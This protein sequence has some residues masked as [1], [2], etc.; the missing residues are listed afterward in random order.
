MHRDLFQHQ[1]H[2]RRQEIELAR[3]YRLGQELASACPTQR[4]ARRRGPLSWLL[5]IVGVTLVRVG[6]RL[7]DDPLAGTT[8]LFSGGSFSQN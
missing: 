1:E 2:A 3:A 4:R 7:A 8:P 6:M 5:R